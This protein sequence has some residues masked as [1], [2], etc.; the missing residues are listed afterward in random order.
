MS[1]HLT[2]S[3]CLI[4][5]S[6]TWAPVSGQSQRT[7]YTRPV[8][9]CGGE[10]IAESGFI[11]SEGFP[12]FYKPN[13]KCTWYITVPDNHVVMLSFRLFDLE[14]DPQCRYDFVEVYNGHSYTS[15]R[16]GRFCGTFRPG[17]II[18]TSNKMMVE[19]ISDD[20]TGGR[21]FVAAFNG[22][23]PH[24]NDHQFCGG[25]LIKPQ[26]SLKT[27]NWPDSDYP[28]GISCS[29]HI[30]AP[31]NHV[32]EV[33]FEKFDIE[34]DNYCRYDY[35]AFFNGG[36]SDDSRRI[37]K[38]CGDLAPEVIVSSSNEL[39]VQFV[40]DLSVTSDGFMAVYN[41]LPK[42]SVSSTGVGGG[43][44]KPIPKPDKS[45][46]PTKA[47]IK[48]TAKPK[49]KPVKPQQTPKAIPPPTLEPR[50]S[51]STTKPTMKTILRRPK[52]SVKLPTQHPRKPGLSNKPIVRPAPKPGTRT[53]AHPD[54]RTTTNNGS[55]NPLCQVQCKKSGTIESNFCSSNFVIS[56]KLTSVASGPRDALYATVQLLHAYKASNLR[57]QQA[58][59]TMSAKI[60]VTCK[61]CPLFKR[62]VNYVLMGQVDQEG[63]G[64][65]SPESFTVPY[66]A[67]NHGVLSK[68]HSQPC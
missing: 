55:A 19:M 8:F 59:K 58:G 54:Q 40:S 11:G 9:L 65:I 63:R 41:T 53:E 52:P 5:V 22:G 47:S 23:Q 33:K 27:P 66:T 39:L 28:A 57:I 50:I 51:T 60:I 35:V 10:H 6:A 26:G 38:Y 62:G 21:G 29:W 46:R 45:I 34:N 42:G 25:K 3:L 20:G 56:G 12:S 49:V 7:N 30:I 18:S 31:S 1:A 16:L 14:S 67:S 43:V 15:Q 24:V 32:I 64:I 61:R 13:R 4:A 68:L 37:G 2:L 48:T 36:E 44:R 17:A